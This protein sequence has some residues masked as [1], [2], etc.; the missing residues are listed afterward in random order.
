MQNTDVMTPG[1]LYES[2]VAQQRWT[3]DEAQRAALV[4]LDRICRDVRQAPSGTQGLRQRM[5][6]FRRPQA[7]RPPRGLYLWGGVGRGKTLLLD[8]FASALT[9]DVVLRLHF[10]RFMRE[11]HAEMRKLGMRPDPLP[12][13]A[14]GIA[15]RARVLCLDEF[16]VEDIGDAMI[17]AGLL[18]ALFARG[19]A[20]VTTSNTHPDVLYR[21]GLQRA[22]FLP[23]IELIHEHCS[24]W[25]LDSPHDWR[26][27]SL[28]R[29][30]MLQTPDGP[31]AD[32]VLATIFEE[33]AVG[34]RTDGGGLV[35]N[36]RHVP[37]RRRA[38]NIVWFDFAALCEGPRAAPDYIE[39]A[40]CYSTVLI[41][42]VPRLE[43]AQDA[44][45]KRFIHLVDE[46]YDHNVKLALST[47]VPLE[48]LYGGERLRSEFERTQSRL[49]E[50]Q[51][52][53]YLLGA[54]RS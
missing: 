50:M 47:A 30:R 54:Y 5:Q 15:A 12:A 24:V 41:S 21:D 40:N 25:E 26:L 33:R 42:D 10:H 13:V 32:S 43:A 1:A 2:G 3:A 19:V 45:A 36:G 48:Q 6:M 35:I 4:E 14:E 39:L 29:R 28:N 7:P 20:L 9:T 23:A 37:V 17:L 8:M 52:E 46:F 53:A 38:D 51:S 27:R 18:G 31:L 44:P 49:I 22:R 16:L 11:V 34:E